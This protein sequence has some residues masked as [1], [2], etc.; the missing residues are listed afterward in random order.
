M[1]L[2]DDEFLND[3]LVGFLLRHAEHDLERLH[4]EFTGKV[5]FFNTYFYASLTNTVKGTKGFNYE[6]VSRWTRNV[7]IFAYDYVV[8]PINENLHWYFAVICNLPHL[9]K[10]P[11]QPDTDEEI[12]IPQKRTPST[13]R[14]TAR[15]EAT[16]SP[17]KEGEK[18]TRTSFASMSLR[19]TEPDTAAGKVPSNIAP[20][21]IDGDDNSAEWPDN[22]ENSVRGPEAVTSPLRNSGL[23]AGSKAA[24]E[25]AD[26]ES[27]PTKPSEKVDPREPRIITFDSMGSSHPQTAKNL[28]KY[29]EAES[30]DKRSM[31]V[32]G[33]SLKCMT[34]KTIPLQPNFS[35]CGLYVWEYLKFFAQDPYD[36]ILKIIQKSMTASDWPILDSSTMRRELLDLITRLHKEQEGEGPVKGKDE[37]NPPDVVE[38]KSKK[39]RSP[40]PALPLPSDKDPLLPTVID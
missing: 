4:P 23:V 12:E 17:E 5:H 28:R 40:V 6:A 29:L 1:R 10:R 24:K 33:K 31:I 32:D 39:D 13:R 25:Y 35:D 11:Y 3:N 9:P 22:D 20:T 37:K 14:S 16:T 36:F 38:T 34:A 30:L 7:D 26:S 18:D 8:V 27:T 19:D 2:S 15:T 21:L